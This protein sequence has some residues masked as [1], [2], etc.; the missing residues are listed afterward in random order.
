[1][2]PVHLHCIHVEALATEEGKVQ[3]ELG[4]GSWAQAEYK[5]SKKIHPPCKTRLLFA[6]GGL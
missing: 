5:R 6:S 4:S 2:L 3:Q 1:M